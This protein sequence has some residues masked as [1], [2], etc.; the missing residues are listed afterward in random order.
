MGCLVV[1]YFFLILLFFNITFASTLESLLKEYEDTSKESLETLNEKMGYAIVYSQKELKLMQYNRLS[2][3]LKELPIL[4]L[5]RSKHGANNLSLVGSKA[6]TSG[7]FRLFIND[8]EVS[9]TYTQSPFLN[10]Y[11]LPI[12]LVDHIEVY[13]GEGS[14][15]LGNETGMKFIRVYTKKGTKQ[16]GG[17]LKTTFTN[18]NSNSQEMSYSDFLENDWSY[19]AYFANQKDSFE[20]YNKN[21]D[22]GANS[23]RQYFFMDF[24]NSTDK[25]NIGYNSTKQDSYQGL[26]FDSNSDDGKSNSENFY[27]NYSKFFLKDKSLKLQLSTDIIN[28]KY[29]E[30][31]SDGL[32]IVGVTGYLGRF[33]K[34]YN[35]NTQL[36]EKSAS[37][38]KNF[39]Y[40]KNNLFTAINVKNS[41]YK[42]K[43]R[44]INNATE[45]GALSSFDEETSYSIAFQD[46]YKI[47]DN[48]VLVGNFKFEKYLRNGNM[49]DSNE[50]L[51]R[52][53]AIYLPT[54]DLGFKTF[55][56]ISHV[57]PSFYD[58]DYAY[59]SN[60][61]LASQEYKY[62]TVEGTYT[63]NK[64]K[65]ALDYFNVHIDDY[66]YYAD[67]IGF[68]NVDH[69]IKINGFIFEYIYNLDRNSKIQFN[70]FVSQLT[71]IKNNYTDGGYLKYMQDFGNFS[72]F[73]SVIY[74]KGFEYTNVDFRD[75]YELSL[76]ASYTIN[77]NLT[78]SVKGTNLLNKST[79][80][81]LRDYT[82]SYTNP[83]I[84]L[85]DDN[86][87]TISF[88]ME[89]K[90]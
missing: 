75:S 46:D 58:V 31:N 71:E 1:K 13:Y 53:G 52:I 89:W 7:Y 86:D 33:I 2:D 39:N 63:L 85:I 20:R 3:I 80:S 8:H 84:Y 23:K 41:R 5:N 16:N 44:T 49:D 38:S 12:S 60:P 81:V 24:S 43:N 26:S 48:L 90:F 42:V 69:T 45:I 32:A 67:P 10:W 18:R 40:E 25:I 28:S 82:T 77:K 36:I 74:R 9:S 88:S 50:K 55:Y 35:E 61:K 83:N 87:R 59:R 56:T 68:I 76:G 54:K 27:I 47:L 72:Y 70:Y 37:L 34:S 66:I 57:P 22:L 62:F 11:D 15:T 4:T 73:A 79:Q 21:D 29:E 78:F 51:Y 14:F 30:S 17:N 19:F 65:F 6:E 64:S